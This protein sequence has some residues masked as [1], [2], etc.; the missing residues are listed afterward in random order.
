VI[1]TLATHEVG[2]RRLRNVRDLRSLH[3]PACREPR[4]A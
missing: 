4:R 3:P 1:E 2:R